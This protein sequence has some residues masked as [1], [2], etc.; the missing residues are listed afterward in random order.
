M[1]AEGLEFESDRRIHS[2]SDLSLGESRTIGAPAHSITHPLPATSEDPASAIHEKTRSWEAVA[3][4]PAV[5]L[6]GSRPS[7]HGAELP[8]VR[9]RP[10]VP[11][12]AEPTRLAAGGPPRLV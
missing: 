5:R 10:A 7:P 1:H 9:P 6:S 8:A 4:T 2:E 11:A 3:Q 12:A